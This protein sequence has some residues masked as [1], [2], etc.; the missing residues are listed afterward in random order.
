MAVRTSESRSSI[1][2]GFQPFPTVPAAPNTLP[3]RIKTSQ[4]PKSQANRNT[5]TED[6]IKTTA[7]FERQLNANKAIANLL[8]IVDQLR[9]NVK[10]AEGDM[11]SLQADLDNA[12][13][14]QRNTQAKMTAAENKV[15]RLKEA[16][17]NMEG[18]IKLL[19]QQLAELQNS[20]RNTSNTITTQQRAIQDINTVNID[21]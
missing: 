19:N 20:H 11:V 9:A 4:A 10:A 13:S 17:N 21:F 15:S 12:I 6:D 5:I 1:S 2:S 14:F 18:K 7:I 16:I 8:D 3:N